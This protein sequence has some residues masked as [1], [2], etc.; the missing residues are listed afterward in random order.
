MTIQGCEGSGA[1]V[2][3]EEE[4][5]RRRAASGRTPLF[6]TATPTRASVAAPP[7]EEDPRRALCSNAELLDALDDE[8]DADGVLSRY[9]AVPQRPDDGTDH[10]DLGRGQLDVDEILEALTRHRDDARAVSVDA[11]PPRGTADLAPTILTRRHRRTSG[12]PH[13]RSLPRRKVATVMTWILIIVG[14][15][16]WATLTMAGV[17]H[18]APRPD[19]SSPVTTAL[20]GAGDTQTYA[21]VAER[22]VADRARSAGLALTR[23]RAAA[24]QPRHRPPERR[25]RRRQ[26]SHSVTPHPDH[27]ATVGAQTSQLP[28]DSAPTLTTPQVATGEQSPAPRTAA[29][30]TSQPASSHAPAFGQDGTLGPGHSPDS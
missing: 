21:A 12:A 20:T 10:T 11:A 8:Q 25:Q 16:A 24:A 9:Q 30:Q 6:P 13:R 23:S 14:L 2:V 17:H 29:P 15:C 18:S 27:A 28:R 26:H 4:V 19:H 5:N 22:L 3:T 1:Q 7:D